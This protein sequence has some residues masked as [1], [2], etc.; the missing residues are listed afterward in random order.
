MAECE[1]C[2]ALIADET[3][4][5]VCNGSCKLS[6]HQQCAGFIRGSRTGKEKKANWK[7]PACKKSAPNKTTD[8]RGIMQQFIEE[9]RKNNETFRKEVI[10]KLNDFQKTL[11]FCSDQSHNTVESNKKLLKELQDIKIQNKSLLEENKCLKNQ[12][13]EMK[14]EIIDLQQYSRRLNVEISNLPEAPNENIETVTQEIS[15]AVNMDIT[16]KISI[17]HRVPTIRKDKIKPIIIQFT[18]LLDK[19]KFMKT[20]KQGKLT[21][22]LINPIFDNIPVYFNDHLCPEMKKLLFHCKVYKRDNG[23]KF[24]WCRDGKVFLRRS[25]GSTIYRVKNMSDLQNITDE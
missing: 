13:Q 4:K 9:L 18:T 25:E 11:E 8:D 17:I 20:A 5:I 3:D 24:C 7:C 16:N 1:A 14:S 21:A 10:G 12:V 2:N 22:N 6:F 15:K 19:A 23:F